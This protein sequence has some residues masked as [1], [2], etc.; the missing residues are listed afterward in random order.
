MSETRC[1]IHPDYDG[2]ERP[3]SA[4]SACSVMY[5]STQS[6]RYTHLEWSALDEVKA[7]LI[8]RA[9]PTRRSA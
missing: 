1:R 4:C 7:P 8:V 5:L 2:N 3:K 9:K 6:E